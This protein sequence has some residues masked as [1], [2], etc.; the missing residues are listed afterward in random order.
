MHGPLRIKLFFT[1]DGK[2]SRRGK[3]AAERPA[4]PVGWSDLLCPLLSRL[5]K[6][7]GKEE[8]QEAMIAEIAAAIAD[9]LADAPDRKTA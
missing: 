4:A 6:S 8:R 7:Q 1:Y 2:F 5:A 9:H 3:L